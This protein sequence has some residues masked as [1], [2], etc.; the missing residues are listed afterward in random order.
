M[1]TIKGKDVCA[2][3][4]TAFLMEGYLL[5]FAYSAAPQEDQS[6][7]NHPQERVVVDFCVA[8]TCQ[9]RMLYDES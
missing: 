6:N 3:V 9:E 5:Y 8:P 2:F 4:S 1:L 7:P